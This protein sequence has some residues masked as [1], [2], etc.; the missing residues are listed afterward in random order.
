MIKIILPVQPTDTID[1][2]SITNNSKVLVYK[3]G[4]FYGMLHQ[5][6]FTKYD[7]YKMFMFLIHDG[8]GINGYHESARAACEDLL[9]L[10][11]DY[12]LYLVD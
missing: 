11:L 5:F 2:N 10:S 9:R 7:N 3:G 1:T 4:K 12:E 6:G 8:G